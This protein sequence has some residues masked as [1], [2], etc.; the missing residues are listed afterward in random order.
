MSFARTP[1]H[2]KSLLKWG[3]YGFFSSSKNLVQNLR[4]EKAEAFPSVV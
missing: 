1:H 4:I 2:L 3:F